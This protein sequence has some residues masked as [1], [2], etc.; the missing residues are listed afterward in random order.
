M[1][2]LENQS[3]ENLKQVTAVTVFTHMNLKSVERT[4]FYV[5]EGRQHLSALSES[6]TV[7][8]T[9]SG[10]VSESHCAVGHSTSEPMRLPSSLLPTEQNPRQRTWF[11]TNRAVVWVGLLQPGLCTSWV[12]GCGS[13]SV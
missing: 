8:A 13:G 12:L 9:A 11:F 1:N 2:P 6:P 5:L 7:S 10:T 4:D 3:L